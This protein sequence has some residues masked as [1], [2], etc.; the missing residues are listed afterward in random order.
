MSKSDRDKILEIL[1]QKGFIWYHEDS[2]LS[3]TISEMEQTGE[4]VSITQLGIN[5]IMNGSY[6]FTLR[7]DPFHVRCKTMKF[8]NYIETFVVSD[9]YDS[10]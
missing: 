10:I 8:P 3:D 5:T 7:D 6:C 9:L 1:Y 2:T 4:L